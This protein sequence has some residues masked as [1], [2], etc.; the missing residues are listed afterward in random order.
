MT[1]IHRPDLPVRPTPGQHGA[2]P[3]GRGA[4]PPT[5]S[6]L[7]LPGAG[8]GSALRRWS[9]L[10]ELVVG[11]GFGLVVL[12]VVG[13]LPPWTCLVAAALA[14]LCWRRDVVLE[15][16]RARAERLAA[17]RRYPRPTVRV[18]RDPRP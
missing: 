10:E 3:D 9:Q 14:A 2:H 4:E 16:R 17:C 15:R 18:C 8:R 5:G 12:A 7:S 1:R 6:S 13:L 11:V